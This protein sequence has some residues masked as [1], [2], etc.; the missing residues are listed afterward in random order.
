MGS[1]MRERI[2]KWWEGEFVPYDDHPDNGVVMFGGFTHRHW[3]SHA[4][5][6]GVGFLGR[7]WKWVIGTLIALTIP[8]MTY[9]RFF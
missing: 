5:Q 7:E 4:A 8:I 6:A 9:M 3:T 2:R 1:N